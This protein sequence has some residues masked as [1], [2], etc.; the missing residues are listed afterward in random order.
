[1]YKRQ[2]KKFQDVRT[3]VNRAKKDGISAEW[4]SFPDAPLSITDQ[5]T[6]ISEEWV[7]DKG[8]PEMGFTL[9]GLEEIDDPQV[10]CLVAVDAERTVHGVTS[11]M[12]VYR[13]GRVVGWTLDFM[14]RRSEGFRP[15]M[16][17]LI[18]S[19]AMLL[20][21]E[22][23]EF[24]SLSGAPLAKVGSS[25]AAADTEEDLERSTLSTVLDR[26]L[27][28]LGK[29]L[30]PVYGF[31]SLLAF[32]SK[33]QPEYVPMHMTFADPVALPSIGNAIGR[34]Y[35]PEVSIGQGV[36]LVRTMIGGNRT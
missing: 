30:E 34:A 36:R 33:F 9:G 32:K 10:R 15:A 12:P 8:M 2:G 7:A 16:E 26:L 23:A 18:A 17:F 5:I 1:M 4:I 14:R 28:V 11:W 22:G 3:A 24:V 19:A 13:D 29:T 21:E 35:L 25:E 20:K 27:D 6:A 31:R